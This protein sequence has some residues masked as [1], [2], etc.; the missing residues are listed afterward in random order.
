MTE[1]E[2][3]ILELLRRDPLLPQQDIAEQ[4]N[5]SRSAVASHIANLMHKGKI[6]GKGYLL[7]E[8]PY[9]VVVGG[10]NIDLLGM[11]D[12]T[13][14]PQDSTPG[15]VVT[16][17]GGV[18]RNIAENL[19][20]LGTDTRLITALGRDNHGRYLLSQSQ[21]A[22]VDCHSCFWLDGTTPS[23]LAIH[24]QG[25]HMQLAI[26]DT[27]LLDQLTPSLLAQRRELLA[28]AAMLIL[29]TNLSAASLD[30]LLCEFPD[31]TTLVD[32]VSCAKAEKIRDLLP[33]IDILKPNRQE[34]EQLSGIAIKGQA[35]LPRVA[36]YFHELGVR[37]L[38]LSLGRD[39]VF[40][41]DGEQQLHLP[42]AEFPVVNSTGAG[43]ALA[44]GIAHGY[45]Q[46]WPLADK[47]RFAQATALVALS[48]SQTINPR[49]SPELVSEF[50]REFLNH[51]R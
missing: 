4:L 39:G 27:N 16:S 24:D 21:S 13:L 30:Y 17:A 9:A 49:M 14:L 48:H 15:R 42:V 40:V 12:R 51:C 36:G 22:G 46:T 28:N 44:A 11:T 5:I 7:N 35:D 26:A 31:V 34:A 29:D 33:R 45:L 19:A 37:Q 2:L 41:S 18:A 47:G 3:E 1:R 6:R 23:Y 32:T 50:Q 8:A 25:G 20:R 10:A 43:D 38:F